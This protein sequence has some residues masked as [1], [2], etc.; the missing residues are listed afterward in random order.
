MTTQACSVIEEL[1]NS[2]KPSSTRLSAARTILEYGVKWLELSD[3]ET[4]LSSLEKK[5]EGK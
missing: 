1:L 5:M 2:K 4:R 3:I